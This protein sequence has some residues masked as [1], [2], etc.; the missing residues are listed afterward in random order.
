M[1]QE[2]ILA[3]FKKNAGEVVRV[4]FTTYKGK[5][6]VNLRVY[7]NAAEE[8]EDRWL[9]S[10]KGLTLRREQTPELKEAINKAAQEY[11]KELSGAGKEEESEEETT[12]F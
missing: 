3:E 6:L 11:E 2:K 12:P 10:P 8:G 7:Y 9:P 1:D 5:K 4:S